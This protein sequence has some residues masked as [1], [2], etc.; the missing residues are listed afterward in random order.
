[1][2][3][4][5][6]KYRKNHIPALQTPG[7]RKSSTFNPATWRYTGVRHGRRQIGVYIC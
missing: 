6:G 7:F 1:M 4:Y 3:K 2:A 5:L